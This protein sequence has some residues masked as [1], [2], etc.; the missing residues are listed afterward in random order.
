MSYKE[1]IEL[2]L[3]LINNCSTMSDKEFCFNCYQY[4]RLYKRLEHISRNSGEP[5]GEY[6][7]KMMEIRRK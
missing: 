5:L 1:I 2:N 3:E 7:T 4:N 6:H